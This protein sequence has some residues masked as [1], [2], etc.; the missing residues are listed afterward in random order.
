M[1]KS[2]VSKDYSL[3]LAYLRKARQ[4]AGIT[5]EQVAKKL[6]A[7]QSFVSKVERGE[8]R[9]DVVELRQWSKALGIT[10]MDFVAGFENY[11]RKNR[12]S[13]L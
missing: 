4:D 3:F 9:L 12:R 8:R 1:E 11:L 7:T 13:L 5:Q 6:K 10:L 2:I